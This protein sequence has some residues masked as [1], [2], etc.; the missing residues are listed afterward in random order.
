[1]DKEMMNT[2]SAQVLLW[3]PRVL[4]ILF[5]IFISL[6]ALDVFGAG[7]SVGETIFALFMH[8]IPTYLVII[9]LLIGWRWD[10]AGAAAFMALALLYLLMSRGQGL[11]IAIPLAVIGVLFLLNWLVRTRSENQDKA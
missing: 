2:R 4:G 5:A 10:W 9:A 8:L 1:M 7:Y 3:A 11:V 6:F